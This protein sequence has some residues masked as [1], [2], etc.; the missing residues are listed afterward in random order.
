MLKTIF[1]PGLVTILSLSMLAI[2][3]HHNS[4]EFELRTSALHTIRED[5][6]WA[7]IRLNGRDLS[8]YGLSPSIS[9]QKNA[10]ETLRQVNGIRIVLDRSTLL[11]IASPFKTKIALTRGEIRLSGHLPHQADRAEILKM[12]SQTVPAFA[13]QDE[14]KTA[15]GASQAYLSLIAQALSSVSKFSGWEIEVI[16]D[17]VK[18]TTSV[19]NG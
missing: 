10:L 14:T 8:L 11:P 3:F 5:H 17:Q 15:R 18:I 16:D 9:A 4:V 19:G 13:I 2:W 1:W 6:T 7:E 12:I